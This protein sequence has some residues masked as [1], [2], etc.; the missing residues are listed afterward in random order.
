MIY[1]TSHQLIRKLENRILTTGWLFEVTVLIHSVSDYIM[2]TVHR[3]SWQFV[4]HSSETCVQVH[5]HVNI[6]TFLKIWMVSQWLYIN[7]ATV[8]S[9]SF[10]TI[11]SAWLK[12]L[13][14]NEMTDT[15]V[16]VHVNTHTS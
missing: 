6:H 14:E 5:V 7:I 12:E 15:C 1:F 16:H 3:P 2:A 11:Y 8:H 9:L 4:V 10:L 13:G